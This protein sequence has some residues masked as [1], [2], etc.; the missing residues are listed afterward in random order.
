M[1]FVWFKCANLSPQKSLYFIVFC[2][3]VLPLCQNVP[4]PCQPLEDII[5]W[6]Y[7]RIKVA[8]AR[9]HLLALHFGPNCWGEEIWP[10]FCSFL[11]CFLSFVVLTGGL[12]MWR[13]QTSLRFLIETRCSSCLTPSPLSVFTTHLNFDEFLRQTFSMIL[14]WAL[15]P[16]LK[17]GGWFQILVKTSYLTQ[18]DTR[19][20]D[21]QLSET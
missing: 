15:Q 20:K 4:N 7:E 19:Q 8:R 21:L 17:C 3:F 6:S 18:I 16:F 14:R 5:L 1:F 2:L 10:P 11:H 9:P 13:L 12:P